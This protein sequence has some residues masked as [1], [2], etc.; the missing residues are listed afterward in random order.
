MKNSAER[1]VGYTIIGLVAAAVFILPGSNGPQVEGDRLSF[2]LPN[3]DGETVSSSDP[4]LQGKVLLVNLWGTWC[5]PC[6]YEIPYLA[7]LQEDYGDQGFEVIG[8]EFPLYAPD[9]VEERAA[10]LR[11]F[12]D[13]LGVNYTILMGTQAEQ[14][15]VVRELPELR[16]FTSFPTSIFIGR[17]GTV[18]E[19]TQ[20]FYEG[21]MPHYRQLI[22]SLLEAEFDS[23]EAESS[24]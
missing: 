8:I 14:S 18:A 23:D 21:D 10:S 4:D 6:R 19:I 13:D 15:A 1:I 2:S 11:K 5:P 16:N 22:E 12:G 7:K 9:S 20:G 17:D 3:L 24:P